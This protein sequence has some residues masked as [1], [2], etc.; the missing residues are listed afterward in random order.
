[1]SF[2]QDQRPPAAE[3]G[4]LRTSTSTRGP[5][6]GVDGVVDGPPVEAVPVDGRLVDLVRCISGTAADLPEDVPEPV[7][8]L[9]VHPAVDERVVGGAGHGQPVARE[10]DVD[11]VGVVPDGRVLIA[12][13]DQHVQGGPAQREDRDDDDHHFDHLWANNIIK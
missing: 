9:L 8:V 5:Y 7:P 2:H 4:T 12:R 6:A 13:H 10:P 1:M 11:D 3:T